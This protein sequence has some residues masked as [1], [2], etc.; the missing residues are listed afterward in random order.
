M[1]ENVQVVIADAHTLF[2]DG[3]RRCWRPPRMQTWWGKSRPATTLLPSELA[4][5]IRL[6]ARRRNVRAASRTRL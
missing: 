1:M 4:Q 2:R 3:L 5:M 6:A